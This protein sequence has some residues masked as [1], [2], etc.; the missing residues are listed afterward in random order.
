MNL[1][2]ED[3][4]LIAF[5]LFGVFY[6]VFISGL[7]HY[8]DARK[9]AY[10]IE[11]LRSFYRFYLGLEECRKD[12]A[13]ELMRLSSEGLSS[14]IGGLDGLIK[15]CNQNRG[16]YEPVSEELKDG[17]LE[18]KLKDGLLLILFYEDDGLKVDF[19]SYDKGR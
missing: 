4:V 17:K 14:T 7:I 1:K 16:K 11:N 2:K 13:A 9:R 18:V 19:I 6:P 10:D 12:R 3:L 15:I 5:M 8:E